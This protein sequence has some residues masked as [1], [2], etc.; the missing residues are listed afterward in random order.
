MQFLYP[1][2]SSYLKS[3]FS[4]FISLFVLLIHCVKSVCRLCYSVLHFSAFSLN[5]ERYYL[6]C[7]HSECGKMRTRITPNT[8]AFTQ[9]SLSR[10]S[11]KQW[12][13][14]LLLAPKYLWRK[15]QYWVSVSGNSFKYSNRAS[16]NVLILI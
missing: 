11:D 8:V 12:I 4:L 1:A 14:V 10:L 3:L 13:V 7:I 16:S 2:H 6:L 15:Q 5:T 9:L